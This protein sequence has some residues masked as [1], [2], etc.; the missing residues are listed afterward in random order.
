MAETIR[1][2]N[3]DNEFQFNAEANALDVIDQHLR[4]ICRKNKKY[5]K[6]YH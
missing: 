5:S 2:N 6:R 3:L 1:L 4:A